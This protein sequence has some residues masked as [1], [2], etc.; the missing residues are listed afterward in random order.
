MPEGKP[1]ILVVE[2][3]A[4]LLKTIEFRLKKEGFEIVT[5]TNGKVAKEM[6]P[7]ELPDLIVSDIMMPYVSGLEL[8]K[9]V[10]DF[11]EKDIPV[12]LLTT[13]RQE[14]NVMKAFE[15]GADEFMTKPFSPAEL[16]V[17]VKRILQRKGFKMD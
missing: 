2:D 12:I 1:K 14:N 11:K 16:V 3:E 17:R 4:M 13:L 15:L 10:K 6:I 7:I 5:A 9:H 8:V